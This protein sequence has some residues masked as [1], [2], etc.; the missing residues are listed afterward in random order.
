MPGQSLKATGSRQR[1]R[2]R[3]ALLLFL[4]P[5]ALLLASGPVRQEKTFETTPNP[6]IDL[7]NLKGQVTVRGWDKPQVHVT[8]TNLAPQTVEVDPE[9]MPTQGPAE[10]VHLTT[11]VLD[12]KVT[13]QDETV[14]Y[15]LEVPVGSSLH[16]RNPQ[17]S[18]RIEKLQAD[19]LVESVGG[20]ISITDVAGH[21]AASSVGGDIEIIR[22][23]GRVEVVSIT[24]NLRFEGPTSSQ[25]RGNTTSGKI[26]YSGDFVSG[27]D[28]TLSTYSGDLDIL[29]P[30]TASIE[31]NARSMRGHIDNELS[32]EPKR[33]FGPMGPA[34]S[35][36]GTHSTGKATLQLRSYSG[37]IRIRPQ[38]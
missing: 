10:K 6:R 2:G 25:L 9:P 3:K 19:A 33:H 31:L 26:V 22:P 20:S 28:Y 29:C 27:A 5:P 37:T 16:I 23:A 30:P 14:D 7:Y 11:H 8:W 24:G 34:T 12:S 1:N 38:Q 4:A 18:V 36:L 21:L 15:T 35:L 32:I 13:G 17:G